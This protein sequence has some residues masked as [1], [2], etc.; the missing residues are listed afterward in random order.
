MRNILSPRMRPIM[1]AIEAGE[2]RVID[3]GKGGALLIVGTNG[4][5][6]SEQIHGRTF[7]AM[8]DRGFFEK[9]GNTYVMTDEGRRVAQHSRKATT[10]R[11]RNKRLKEMEVFSVGDVKTDN[12][13]LAMLAVA[14]ELAVVAAHL[15]ELVNALEN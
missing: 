5:A 13:S 9:V 15:R 2:A 6:R 1:W 4:D 7:D 8:L 14:N 3:N 11:R 12:L 10:T